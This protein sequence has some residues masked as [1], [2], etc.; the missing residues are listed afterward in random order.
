MFIECPSCKS[1]AQIPESKEGA[2]VRCPECGRVYVARP[3]GSRGKG[4]RS[5]VDPTRYV[6]IGGGVVLLAIVG[7]MVSRAKRE[8]AP[9]G[10]APVVAAEERPEPSV[11]GWSSALVQFAVGLHQQVEQGNAIQLLSAV[12]FPRAHAWHTARAAAAAGEGEPVAG[13]APPAEAWATLDEAA[14]R[15]FQDALVQA[16]TEGEYRELLADWVPYDG[17]VVSEDDQTAVVRLRVHHRSE[18]ST[19][20]RNV[21]WRLAKDGSRWRAWAWERWLSP[22]ELKVARAPKTK[23]V[24]RT[25]SDGSVVIEGEVTSEID[26]HPDTPAELIPQIE[27]AIDRLIDPETLPKELT[28]ARTRLREIGKH[29]VPGL[30]KRMGS[31]PLDSEANLIALNQIHLI[32]QDLTG[33]ATT[34]EV[35]VAMG[36]TEERQDSGVKQWFGWYDKKFKRFWAAADQVVEEEDPLW[37]DPD[38]QPRT[39][40]ERREFEKLRAA[41]RQGGQ[42]G[43]DN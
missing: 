22:E 8:V 15:A 25:L 31:I 6:L 21:E 23:T 14:R 34:F 29:A 5:T 36:T 20:D 42:D 9:S 41:A 16:M 7:V 26:Y 43:Q 13:A 30:L 28:A 19:P 37:D 12:D 2:K 40:K 27:S 17:F 4:Q 38:F 39:E 3:V 18:P 24:K 32:L 35:H 10:P 33:Y 11:T 1:R